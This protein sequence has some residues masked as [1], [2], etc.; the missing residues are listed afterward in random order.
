MKNTAGNH[1]TDKFI[2]THPAFFSTNKS[3]GFTFR[4][5]NIFNELNFIDDRCLVIIENDVWIGDSV[6][7]LGGVTIGNGAIVGAGSIVTKDVPPYAI[8]FGVPAK[9][10]RFRFTDEQIKVIESSKWWN[11]QHEWIK[12]N[13]DKFDNFELFTT[14]KF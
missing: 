12:S 14:I 13:A 3:I 10:H 8:V 1:P 4:D 7:I 9:I 5:R 6:T 11:K 2:S